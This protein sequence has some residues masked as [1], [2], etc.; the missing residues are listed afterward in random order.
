MCTVSVIAYPRTLRMVVS[1]DELRTRRIA[2]PPRWRTLASETRATWPTD[3]DTGGTWVAA[4]TAGLVVTLLNVNVPEIELPPRESLTSRGLLIPPLLSLHDADAVADQVSRL[5][6]NRYAPFRVIAVDREAAKIVSLRWDRSLLE[7]EWHALPGCFVSSGL[8]DALVRPRLQLFDQ[9]VRTKPNAESQ[10]A[11]HRH[12]WTDRPEV[13]VLMARP[14]ARTVS[15][16]TIEVPLTDGEP[17]MT[18]L[19]V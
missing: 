14:D 10:D 16:T 13:S 12:T 15:I 11:F 1:R 17:R 18:Y 8:G 7:K 6:L 3:A 19:P 2:E 4:N 9:L 5:D